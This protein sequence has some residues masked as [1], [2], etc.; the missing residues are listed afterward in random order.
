MATHSSV[1]ALENPRDGG[2]WWAVI[3]GVA[4]SRTRLKRL[5]SS[6][7]RAIVSFKVRVSL[8][9]LY[10]VDLSIGVSWIL[11]SPRILVLLLISPFFFLIFWLH[12]FFI[13]AQDF[14]ICSKLGLLCNYSTLAFKSCVFLDADHRLQRTQAQQLW[15]AGL[16]ALGHLKSSQARSQM[17]ILKTG[18]KG[19]TLWKEFEIHNF[20]MKLGTMTYF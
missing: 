1:L 2:A 12:Q 14:S 5:S 8:L 10:L 19:K 17:H 15:P 9:F 18:S 3:Y 13:A 11:K 7:S 16:V 6:S 20:Y 4:Q